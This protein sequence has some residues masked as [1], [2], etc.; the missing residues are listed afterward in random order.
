MMRRIT[1][2][3]AAAGL[4]AVMMAAPAVGVHFDRNNEHDNDGFNDCVVIDNT[5][6]CDDDFGDD[7]FG[8]FGFDD[9]ADGFAVENEAES[10]AVDLS[11][12][13]SNTGD[14]ASQCVPALQF[15]NTGNFNNAP[16]FAQNGSGGFVDE[17]NDVVFF[18]DDD[19]GLN[20][21]VLFDNRFDGG[22]IDDFEA[23]GIDVSFSPELT[24]DC[25]STV[26]QSSAASSSDFWPTKS[27]DWWW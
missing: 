14:Y 6:V 26:Q 17:R 20:D 19:D 8:F 25:S 18:D 13:V 21:F 22:D 24:V 16:A 2:L 11:F 10:G 5:L 23:G 1:M 15:G 3:L 7:D 9:D 12:D 4:L 27:H